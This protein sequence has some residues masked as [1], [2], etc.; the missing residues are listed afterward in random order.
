MPANTATTNDVSTAAARLGVAVTRLAR[1]LRQQD[2]GD[3]TPTMR[4]ALG[5]I[6]RKGPITLGD[7]AAIEHVAPPTITKVVGRMVDDGLVERITDTDDRRVCRV[8][9][10]RAGRRRLEADRSRRRAWLA[11]RIA[12]LPEADQARLAEA[13]DVIEQLV[14]PPKDRA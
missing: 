12:G 5:T 2:T 6:D 1:R 3:L 11:T 10:S 14:G 9:L 7:L 4:A 8:Q 13:L